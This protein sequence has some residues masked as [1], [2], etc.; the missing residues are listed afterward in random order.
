M[1]PAGRLLPGLL[2]LWSLAA[3][4][5]QEVQRCED[6]AGKVSYANGPCPPGTAAVRPLPP[7]GGPSAA[8]Q[9]AAQQRAKQD[10]RDAAAVDR[11]RKAEEERLAREQEQAQAKAKKQEAQCKRLEARLRHAQQDLA[12][13]APNRR[14]EA[15]RVARRA[16]EAYVEDCGPPRR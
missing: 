11:A 1:S 9:K 5:A 7:A 12:G 15:Q 4:V 16:E 3:A 14:S 13:A 2:A 8:D 6:P 10:V